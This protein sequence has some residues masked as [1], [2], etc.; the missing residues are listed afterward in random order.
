MAL[1]FKQIHP[2]SPGQVASADLIFQDFGSDAAQ[3]LSQLLQTQIDLKLISVKQIP[4]SRLKRQFQYPVC[5]AKLTLNTAEEPAILLLNGSIAYT[6]IDRM[7]GGKGHLPFF[8]QNFSNLERAVLRKLTGTLLKQ[9][10]INFKPRFK[11]KFSIDEICAET[12]EIAGI[13]PYA[14]LLSASFSI[15]IDN[16]QGILV[17]ALPSSALQKLPEQPLEKYPNSLLSSLKD[18]EFDL[19]VRLGSAL[20]MP[21]QVPQLQPGDIL[22]LKQSSNAPLEVLLENQPIL[23]GSPGIIN[24]HK[25]VELL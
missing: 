20:L 5:C 16:L 15:T 21:E 14:P 17:I 12:S 23:H 10:E 2:L 13:I 22:L 19:K 9:L 11:A 1:D 25:G 8:A 7:L 6:S 24:E 18:L 4:F 3:I